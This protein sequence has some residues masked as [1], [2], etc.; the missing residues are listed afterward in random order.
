MSNKKSKGSGLEQHYDNVTVKS[1]DVVL[2]K[3]QKVQNPDNFS[4]GFGIA[5]GGALNGALTRPATT[6]ISS[7]GSSTS[8]STASATGGN[9]KASASVSQSQSAHAKATAQSHGKPFSP[10]NKNYAGKIR[11]PTHSR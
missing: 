9:A 7:G 4:T 8:T 3:P 2:S 10:N 5:I 6:T 1:G 11:P